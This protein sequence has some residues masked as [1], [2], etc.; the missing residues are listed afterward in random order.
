MRKLQRIVA[1]GLALALSLGAPAAFGASVE[2]ERIEIRAHPGWLPHDSVHRIHAVTTRIERLS[3]RKPLVPEH[4][5]KR[6]VRSSNRKPL[7]SGVFKAKVARE[8]REMRDANK[9]FRVVRVEAENPEKSSVAHEQL[10]LTPPFERP[11]G[12]VSIDP[13]VEQIFE[14]SL[15]AGLRTDYIAEKLNVSAERR[16]NPR[17]DPSGQPSELEAYLRD[18][19]D[20][21]N[22]EEVADSF[23]QNNPV[24]V[25]PLPLDEDIT[26]WRL[27]TEGS[28]RPDGNYYFCCREHIDGEKWIDARGLATPPA[29][30]KSDL[31]EVTIPKGTIVVI[32]PIADQ[33]AF[34]ALGGNVQVFVPHVERFA[35]QHYKLKDSGQSATDIVVKATTAC[36]DSVASPQGSGIVGVPEQ[37]PTTTPASDAAS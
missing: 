11:K 20:V 3:S 22:H 24:R 17:R 27:F 23:D 36:S 18:E 26:L 29:N 14:A 37:S 31:A 7:S 21:K 2:G 4:P 9:S 10:T 25:G 6:P 33:P 30:I 12:R 32:G 19:L 8:L 13:S 16:L 28:S 15:W 1:L 35:Y 5:I 34:G